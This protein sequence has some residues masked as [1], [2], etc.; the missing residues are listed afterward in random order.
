[1]CARVRRGT[2]AWHRFSDL[3]VMCRVICGGRHVAG[4]VFIGVFIDARW[5]S[6]VHV[7]VCVCVCVCVYVCVCVCVFV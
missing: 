5:C 3:C 6:C 4:V 7:C 1:M 2:G